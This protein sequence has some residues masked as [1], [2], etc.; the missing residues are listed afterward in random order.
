ML[1]HA[2]SLR[3]RSRVMSAQVCTYMTWH[4]ITLQR[5]AAWER[6]VARTGAGAGAAAAAGAIGLK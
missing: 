3:A 4:Y 6:A 1:E 5:W 2:L